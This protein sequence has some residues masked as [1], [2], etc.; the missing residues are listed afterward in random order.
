MRVGVVPGNLGHP[1][2]AHVVRARQR[3][4]LDL[5]YATC[6][7]C[8]IS[9]ATLLAASVRLDPRRNDIIPQLL[10]LSFD[11]V[12]KAVV[13]SF[14]SSTDFNPVSVANVVKSLI[15]FYKHCDDA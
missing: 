15:C 13:E 14:A 6:I 2:V 1:L 5:R 9:G 10:A 4:A 12:P 8:D 3:P 7:E 11:E